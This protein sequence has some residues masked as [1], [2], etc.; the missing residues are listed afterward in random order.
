MRKC[1]KC[2]RRCAKVMHGGWRVVVMMVMFMVNVDADG[3]DANEKVAA[4]QQLRFLTCGR[5]LT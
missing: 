1:E 5:C 3:D 2:H 4:P